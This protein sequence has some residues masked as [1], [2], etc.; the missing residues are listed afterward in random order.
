MIVYSVYAGADY[1]RM[2]TVMRRSVHQHNPQAT[3]ILERLQKP[4]DRGPDEDTGYFLTQLRQWSEMVATAWDELLLLDA[5]MLCRGDLSDGWQD[6]PVAVTTR[7]G[8]QKYNCGAMFVRPT[9]AV[10]AFFMQWLTYTRALT[11][12]DDSGDGPRHEW[13]SLDQAALAM[14][15]DSDMAICD[16]AEIPCQQWNA[17]QQNWSSVTDDTRLVHIKGKL[18]DVC[19]S[20]DT[21][22]MG[23]GSIV[24][25][26]QSYE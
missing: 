13:G 19:L 6:A 15:I 12:R 24:E 11:Q 9:G 7:E 16:V 4:E 21:S 3:V 26:W 8:D 25:E 14:M 2:V 5:D 22:A 18:R 20:G 23:M 1:E 17:C 10:A